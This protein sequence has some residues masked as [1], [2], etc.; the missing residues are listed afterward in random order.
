ME[1]KVADI[2]IAAV[3]VGSL[4]VGYVTLKVAFSDIESKKEEERVSSGSDSGTGMESPPRPLVLTGPS[5]SGKSTLLKLL[6]D[7]FPDALGF[8]VSHTTRNPRSGEK[9]GREYH[10]TSREE[11]KKSVEEGNFIETAEFAGNVYGTSKQAVRDV[12]STGRICVLDIDIQGVISMRKTDLNPMYVF[13]K[14]PSVEELEKRLRARNT[15][16]QE[17]LQRR[18]DRA[19]TEMREGHVCSVMEEQMSK[20]R[21]TEETLKKR[22]SD[23]HIL[24]IGVFIAWRT[25]GPRLDKISQ[26]DVE[27][28]DRDGHN[29]SERRGML[30]P[31]WVERNGDDATYYKL[32]KAM[33]EAR[34]GSNADEVCKLLLPDNGWM[35]RTFPATFSTFPILPNMSALMPSRLPS[36]LQPPPPPPA[37]TSPGHRLLVIT[38]ASGSGTKPLLQRLLTGFPNKFEVCVPRTTRVPKEGETQGKEYH[39]TTKEEMQTGINGGKYLEWVEY[40]DAMYGTSATA[41]KEI[42]SRG[43]ICVLEMDDVKRVRSIKEHADTDPYLVLIQPSSRTEMDS[44]MTFDLTITSDEEEE[45]YKTLK[46]AL[47]EESAFSGFLTAKTQSQNV[48][49]GIYNTYQVMKNYVIVIVLATILGVY[50]IPL[51]F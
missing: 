19:K 3:A 1:L 9:D 33:L 51:E 38:G 30:L 40:S 22:C 44:D 24:D 31:L 17:S 11:M 15:E 2:A 14:P 46:E 41:V 26:T 7:E 45:A 25:V 48:R 32:I 50:V 12:Q 5:G 20:Y 10:F 49:V 37:I 23:G 16:S 29:E 43:K 6:F 34:N 21:L 18:L 42:Q 4:I 35:S 47:T 13:I 8:S 36:R 39:F 27:D 28:I